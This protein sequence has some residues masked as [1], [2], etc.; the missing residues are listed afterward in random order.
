MKLQYCSGKGLNLP[1]IIIADHLEVRKKMPKNYTS[2][3]HRDV[4]AGGKFELEC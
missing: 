3:M 2:S 1:N 4:M